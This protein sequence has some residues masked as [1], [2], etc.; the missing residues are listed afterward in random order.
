MENEFKKW[1]KTSEIKDMDSIKGDLARAIIDDD[2]FPIEDNKEV[3]N[4]YMKSRLIV[5][6]VDLVLQE[7]REL[8]V[9]YQKI[10]NPH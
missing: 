4:D 6:N 9:C 1:L 8:Y 5:P 7:L 2:D 10:V 3:I